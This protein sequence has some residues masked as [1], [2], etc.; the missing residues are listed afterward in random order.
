MLGY[1]SLLDPGRNTYMEIH[2]AKEAIDA[3]LY[4]L[5]TRIGFPVSTELYYSVLTRPPLYPSAFSLYR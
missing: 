3:V 5:Q 2:Y 4:I 1:L